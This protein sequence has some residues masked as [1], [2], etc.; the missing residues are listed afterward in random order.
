[1][2]VYAVAA[3]FDLPTELIDDAEFGGEFGGV[4]GGLLRV[5]TNLDAGIIRQALNQERLE[6]SGII[7][8]G[9]IRLR[10]CGHDHNRAP[11]PIGNIARRR[12]HRPKQV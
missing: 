2:R 10:E 4:G 7:L 6:D 11:T 1:M 9:L 5:H 8:G 12:R 3:H